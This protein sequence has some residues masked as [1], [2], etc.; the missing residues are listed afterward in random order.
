MPSAIKPSPRPSPSTPRWWSGIDPVA[1]P[2]TRSRVFHQGN[3]QNTSFES[4]ALR[5]RSEW[6]LGL[7]PAE[8]FAEPAVVFEERFEFF[9]PI[10][11]RDPEDCQRLLRV[12]DGRLVLFLVEQYE[13]AV[14]VHRGKRLPRLRIVHGFECGN[15]AVTGCFGFRPALLQ[16]AHCGE[17]VVDDA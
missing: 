4:W 9:R 11:E 17:V 3:E 2:F 6:R 8:F 10:L 1:T 7:S 15:R 13:R 16:P 14:V 12:S 5:R